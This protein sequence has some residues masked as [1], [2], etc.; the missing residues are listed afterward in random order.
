[1]TLYP[2]LPWWLLLPLTAAAVLFL[3]W[4]LV[5]VLRPGSAGNGEPRRDWLLRSALV[6]LLLAAALRPGFPG[7]AAQAATADV[8]VFFVVDTTSSIAAEDYGGS[9]PRLEGVRRDILAIAGELA[10]ARFSLISFDTNAAVRMPL[11]TDATALD[12]MVSVLEPQVTAYSKGS[13]VTVAAKVLKDRLTAARESHPERPRIVYYLG[14][15]EHTSG[16]PPEAFRVDAGLVDG[17]AVLGYGTPQGGRMKENT[18]RGSGQDLGAGEDTG[19]GYIQDRT[20]GSARDALSII[21]EGRLRE[22]AGQLG[23]PYVHRSAVDPVSPMLQD[24]GPPG[25]QRQLKR[26]EENGSLEGRTELYWILAAG[27][28]LLA[29]RE[30]L[31]VLRQWR[32]LRPAKPIQ[33]ERQLKHA[34]GVAK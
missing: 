5:R 7:G 20:A 21:D 26:A 1:M 10:G 19:A 32:Q 6:L 28:F 18:G 29:L 25:P 17:G 11:S 27:A 34:E 12:T 8:N 2:V 9:S 31:L 33:A 15:G 4:R 24:A 13:S 22:I 30:T 16:K 23:V 3:G 14:D